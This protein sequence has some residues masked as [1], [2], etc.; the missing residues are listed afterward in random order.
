MSLIIFLIVGAIAGYLANRI[1]GG[2]DDLVFSL[3][4]G[5]VGAVVG[6]FLAGLVGIV[7]FGLIGQVII[8]TLGAILCIFLWRKFR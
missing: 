1:M 3:I 5:V 8:A 7:A 2:K 6:G 4:I